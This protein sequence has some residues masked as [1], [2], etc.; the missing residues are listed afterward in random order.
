MPKP[1]IQSISGSKILEHQL[2][3]AQLRISV[4][5]EW[6]YLYEGTLD[7]ERNYLKHYA[8]C[9]E[10]IVVLAMDAERVVGASTGLP[11]SAAD[12]DFQKAFVETDYDINTIYYFGE[13]VLLPEYRGQGIGHTFFQ[14]REAKARASGAKYAAFCAVDRSD[15]DPRMPSD[16]R[17]LHSFWQK[18]GYEAQ[19][20]IRASFEWKEIGQSLISRQTLTF[21]LKL[22]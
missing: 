8:K 10:S 18:L 21:W 3:L 9:P 6:P 15:N 5:R 17:S 20:H 22:L 16:Y 12:A 1:I 11:M 4:F 7:Y 19:A 13:S 14:A 2:A